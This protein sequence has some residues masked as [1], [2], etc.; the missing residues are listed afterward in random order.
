VTRDGRKVWLEGLDH[1]VPGWTMGSD[2]CSIT[3]IATG[4]VLRW[5]QT[6][7]AWVSKTGP[8]GAP[9]PM[10]DPGGPPTSCIGYHEAGS[11]FWGISVGTAHPQPIWGH[12]Q[13]SRGVCPPPG[14]TSIEQVGRYVEAYLERTLT[15]AE[16][17]LTPP[18]GAYPGAVGVPVR[19]W[20]ENPVPGET[21][22]TDGPIVQTVE[23]VTVSMDIRL[24]DVTVDWGDGTQSTCHFDAET[25]TVGTPFEEGQDALEF[26]SGC[27][28]TYAAPSIGQPDGVY[29]VTATSNWEIDWWAGT[30]QGSDGRTIERSTGA[31]EVAVA[32]SEI[33]AYR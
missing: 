1:P 21:I 15:P 20:Y 10:S 18:E 5:Q 27:Q 24:R 16:I 31:S 7:G 17:G 26:D 9:V 32:V 33:Q 23:T 4:E 30:S 19:L 3:S 12:P 6:F 29:T 13:T 14:G 28:H 11:W 8:G 22:G 2:G 25:G